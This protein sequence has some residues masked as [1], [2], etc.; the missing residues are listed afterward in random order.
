[1][2]QVPTSFTVSAHA[3]VHSLPRGDTCSE[4]RQGFCEASFFKFL[5]FHV[6]CDHLTAMRV[7]EEMPKTEL[8][9]PWGLEQTI[10]LV[11]TGWSATNSFLWMTPLPR[12]RPRVL[13]DEASHATVSQ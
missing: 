6:A 9:S 4:A 8:R 3:Q 10:A 7:W 12:T 2:A 13:A 11:K 5:Q 1:M